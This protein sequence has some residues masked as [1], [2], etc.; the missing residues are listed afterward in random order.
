RLDQAEPVE[1]RRYQA[2]YFDISQVASLVEQVMGVEEKSEAEQGVRLVVDELTD[3]LLVTATPSQ[4][5]EISALVDRLNSSEGAARRSMR[6]YA[7]RNR[8]VDEVVSLLNQLLGIESA[9]DNAGGSEL[10]PRGAMGSRMG[11]ETPATGAGQESGSGAVPPASAPPG[12]EDSGAANAAGAA[13][14]G[15]SRRLLLTAD[16]QTSSI[17]AIGEPR[18]LE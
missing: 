5:D 1:R 12:V 9:G 4:H 10:T 15:S 2:Q 13:T 6:T 3:T 8:P 16:T 17:I 11:Q 14:A 18:L 7:V